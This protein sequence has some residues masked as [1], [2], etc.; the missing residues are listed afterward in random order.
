MAFTCSHNLNS[1]ILDIL[2]G[3]SFWHQ[4]N[5][6]W[7]CVHVFYVFDTDILVPTYFNYIMLIQIIVLRRVQVLMR[8]CT[9]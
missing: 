4:R 1:N 7:F 3:I 8:L 5:K 6:W 9:S 2:L